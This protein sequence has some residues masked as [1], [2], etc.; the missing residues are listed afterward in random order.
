[1][2]PVKQGRSEAIVSFYVSGM[3][4]CGR[5]FCLVADNCPF[6]N[7]LMVDLYVFA[8][9][10]VGKNDTVSYLCT[11][12]D[13]DTTADDTVLNGAFDEAAVGDQ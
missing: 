13:G 8:D 6:I 2:T 7:N 5:E 11:L 4:G 1:M 10:G 9:F 12:F 3:F